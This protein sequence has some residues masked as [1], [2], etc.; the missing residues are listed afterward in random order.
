MPGLHQAD[1]TA[2]FC[3]ATNQRQFMETF[4][5]HCNDVLVSRDISVSKSDKYQS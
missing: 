1:K 4:P 3:L 5:Q 2:T